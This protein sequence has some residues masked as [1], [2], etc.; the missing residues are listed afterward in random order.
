MA[1]TSVE[2][3]DAPTAIGVSTMTNVPQFLHG[4]EHFQPLKV[5]W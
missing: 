4:R 2:I 5:L 1:V 3:A